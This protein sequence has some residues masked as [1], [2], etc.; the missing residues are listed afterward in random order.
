MC[1]LYGCPKSMPRCPVFAAALPPKVDFTY[2]IRVVNS[3][4][5]TAL[6]FLSVWISHTIA[7]ESTHKRVSVKMLVTPL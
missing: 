7:V 4:T 1:Q 2:N 3:A 5:T 6:F